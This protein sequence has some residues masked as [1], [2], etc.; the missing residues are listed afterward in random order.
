MS[1]RRLDHHY[2]GRPVYTTAPSGHDQKQRP[3]GDERARRPRRNSLP[4]ALTEFA[5][6]L[7]IGRAYR[8]ACP[9]GQGHELFILYDHKWRLLCTKGCREGDI[10]RAFGLPPDALRYRPPVEPRA[11]RTMRYPYFSPDGTLLFEVVRKLN[12]HAGQKRFFVKE[13]AGTRKG[14]VYRLAELQAA[15]LDEPVFWVEGEKDVETL[16]AHGLVAV[17]TSLGADGYDPNQGAWFEGRTVI[18]LPDNDEPGRRYA[19]KVA[20]SLRGIAAK[21]DVVQLPGVPPK[22][23]VSWWL[24]NGGKVADLLQAARVP[25]FFKP[26]KAAPPPPQAERSKT[27]LGTLEAAV[28]AAIDRAEHRSLTTDALPMLVAGLTGTEAWN[29]RAREPIIRYRDVPKQELAKARAGISRAL[30]SLER[31]D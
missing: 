2:D 13:H 29:A 18:I 4:R 11:P 6:P 1:R 23:D 17:T 14:V 30:G 20:A 10:L 3:S 16:R 26:V 7:E 25:S 28:L 8:H 19:G 21:V 24:A 27:P 31:G 5:T 12:V 22:E 9:R 15:P